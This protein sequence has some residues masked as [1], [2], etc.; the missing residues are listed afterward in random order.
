MMT[1]ETCIV[2]REVG[3][4]LQFQPEMVPMMMIYRHADADISMLMLILL[5]HCY[6]KILLTWPGT[7]PRLLPL[8]KKIIQLDISFS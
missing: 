3:F 2:S 5:K 4:C 1:I 6:A 7:S 8:P